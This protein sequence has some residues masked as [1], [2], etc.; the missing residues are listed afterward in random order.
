M[1]FETLGKTPYKR[2]FTR[3][4]ILSS[5]QLTFRPEVTQSAH[6]KS[7]LVRQTKFFTSSEKFLHSDTTRLHWFL[8]CYCLATK[9]KW[10]KLQVYRPQSRLT[11]SVW[12]RSYAFVLTSLKI[13]QWSA[14]I[15]CPIIVTFRIY[16][17]L[18]SCNEEQSQLLTLK[19][20]TFLPLMLKNKL[21]RISDQWWPS[22][23][24]SSY[25]RSLA[26]KLLGET[27]T[28]STSKF[29]LDQSIET[30]LKSKT[31]ALQSGL[32]LMRGPWSHITVINEVR[33]ICD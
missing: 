15:N 21:V 19:T 11:A 16:N 1:N 23:L 22:F 33:I 26:S 10:A 6:G 20:N 32:I 9:D 29:L 3:T 18:A 24:R 7:K 2:H 14:V 30:F 4:H 27:S 12:L 25:S 28:K 13:W 8:L 17:I 5:I 31:K